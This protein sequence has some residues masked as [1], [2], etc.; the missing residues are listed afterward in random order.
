MN[1]KSYFWGGVSLALS[2]VQAAYAAPTIVLPVN[3]CTSATYEYAMPKYIAGDPLAAGSNSANEPALLVFPNNASGKL[4][5]GSGTPL[6]KFSTAAQTGAV[7]G[8]ATQSTSAGKKIYSAAVLKRHV[9]LGA[10]GLGAIYVSDFA[11]GDASTAMTTS[12]FV[13][14]VADFGINVGQAQ[15]PSNS[16]RGLPADKTQNSLDADT[17]PLIGKVGLGDLDIDEAQANLYVVNL[18]DK[19]VYKLNIAAGSTGVPVAYAIPSGDGAAGTEMRPWGLEIAG[20]KLYAGVVYTPAGNGSVADLKAAIYQL[21]LATGVWET[22]PVTTFALD[23]PR[24]TAIWDTPGEWNPWQDD[25]NAFKRH[26]FVSVH[27]QPLLS[28][29]ELDAE[30]AFHIAMLDRAGHQVGHRNDQP[31]GGGSTTGVSAG[32]ILRTWND[33]GTIRL[34]NKG[35]AGAY[36]SSGTGTS[37]K[38]PGGVNAPQGLGGGEFYWDDRV[39]ADHSETGFGGLALHLGNKSLATSI[40]DPMDLDAGGMKVFST[41]NGATTQ[42]Y[43]IYQD[44]GDNAFINGKANGLGD[45]EMLCDPVAQPKVDLSLTKTA[46]PASAKSGDQVVYTL[47]VSNAGPDKATGVKVTDVLPAGLTYVSHAG[48]TYDKVSGEWNVDMVDVG[49]ANAKT[50]TLTVKVN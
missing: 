40:M 1:K 32:D 20:G 27:P 14:L 7:W 34:E 24:G 3:T 39:N 41:N 13:D 42:E 16:A 47:K 30:G 6:S 19:K 2:A 17:F 5:D 48:G 33:N 9:G 37:N 21:D 18:F 25:Y 11:T 26:D 15:V 10:N 28:D 35:V 12:K 50:L 36:T 43:Q 46:L 45:I 44:A 49:S 4:N 8:T 22:T 38:G 31:I 23:Y 29:M